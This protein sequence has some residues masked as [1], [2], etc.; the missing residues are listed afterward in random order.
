[1]VAT[2]AGLPRSISIPLK[3][4]MV[5]I[6]GH[7]GD[8]GVEWMM[9]GRSLIPANRLKGGSSL[10]DLIEVKDLSVVVV[11]VELVR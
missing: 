4:K 7:Y 2:L 5:G 1:M 8:E 11:R 9:N 6:M 3:F 10:L